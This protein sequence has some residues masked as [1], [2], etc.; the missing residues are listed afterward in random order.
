[1]LGWHWILDALDCEERVLAD[2][3][4]LLRALLQ[5]PEALGLT[6]VGEPQL[7]E[8]REEGGEVTLAGVTLLSESHFSLHARPRQR[9]L[10]A[11]LFSCAPF[12]PARA[13]EA[14][15]RHYPFTRHG[16]QVLTRGEGAPR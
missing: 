5:V 10:H 11:D 15:R 9:A 3:E 1:M 16:E 6:R 8:H 12:E 2:R 7:F 14:L 4:A 13:R